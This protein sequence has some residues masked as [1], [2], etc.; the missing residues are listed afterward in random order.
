MTNP[1]IDAIR[2]RFSDTGRKHKPWA[3]AKNINP[4]TFER[5]MQGRYTPR[6]GAVLPQIIRELKA[7]GLWVALKKA[8]TKSAA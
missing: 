7:D 4:D 2:R 1:D 3:R 6:R 8:D 5:F